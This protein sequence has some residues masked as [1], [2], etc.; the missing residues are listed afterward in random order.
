[1][2]RVFQ[3]TWCGGSLS[4]WGRDGVAGTEGESAAAGFSANGFAK[5]ARK[6]GSERL[7]LTGSSAKPLPLLCCAEMV[8]LPAASVSIASRQQEAERTKSRLSNIV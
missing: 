4:A 3:V 6:R 7:R 8:W 2:G 5:D 1:M